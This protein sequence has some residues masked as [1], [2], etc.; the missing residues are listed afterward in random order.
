MI[1]SSP[2]DKLDSVG[3]VAHY[4][5]VLGHVATVREYNG[6]LV[7]GHAGHWKVH[8]GQLVMYEHLNSEQTP[9]AFDC[10]GDQRPRQYHVLIVHGR[11]QYQDLVHQVY[12][13]PGGLTQPLLCL[14]QVG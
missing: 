6:G 8:L 3:H 12:G 4:G 9:T 2:G 11:D 14:G 5:S 10:C 7:G 1:Q 13:Y